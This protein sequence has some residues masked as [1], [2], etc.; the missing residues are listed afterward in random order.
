MRFLKISTLILVSLVAVGLAGSWLSLDRSFGYS[1]AAEVLPD[2]RP[3]HPDGLV[4]IAARGMTYRARVAGLSNNGPGLIL[5]HG[6]P[7]TSW[8][9]KPLLSAASD[10][11]FRVIAFDQRGY[12]PEARPLDVDAY[13]LDV[14]VEDVIAVAKVVGFE[15]FHL[16]GHDWGSIVGWTLTSQYPE[17]VR[18]WT[19]LSIAHP[20][21]I[22]EASATKGTPA[23][24]KVFRIPGLMENIF[25]FGNHL[26]M[27]KLLYYPIAESDL[28]EYLSVFAEPGALE[29]ALNWYRAQDFQDRLADV[30][31]LSTPTLW[32]YGSRDMKVFTGERVRQLMPRFVTGPYEVLELD[33]GHWLIQEQPDAVLQAVLK[34][35]ELDR[36]ATP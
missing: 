21:A 7:E 34:H 15:D 33:A 31:M 1:R 3:N 29:A 23:Y 14:I 6:F 32:V 9:W 22:S 35:I 24:I 12:S 26:F 28:E 11:G 10:A 2:Y 4:R 5:L 25:S 13:T 27:R 20:G 16:V 36:G 30:E 18:S 17:R 8:M 19:S